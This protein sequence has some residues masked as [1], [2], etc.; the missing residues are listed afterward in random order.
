M[1]L[2]PGGAGVVANPQGQANPNGYDGARHLSS[3][4]TLVYMSR[5]RLVQE[6]IMKKRPDCL[7]CSGLGFI[8]V[9]RRAKMY[10][11]GIIHR[12]AKPCKDCS[13]TGKKAV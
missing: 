9:F 10:G 12:Y 3:N 13:S 6:W 8:F 4:H 11:P 7:K 1:S 5:C 2:V